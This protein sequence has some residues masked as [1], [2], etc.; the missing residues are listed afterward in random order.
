MVLGKWFTFG[1][2]NSRVKEYNLD[3]ISKIRKEF[4]KNYFEKD[5]KDY[6]NILFE[7]QKKMI[8]NEIFEVYNHYIFQMGATE[9]FSEWLKTNNTEYEKFVEWY[10]KNENIINPTE[11]NYFQFIN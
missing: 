10:T 3:S 2:L 7:Y 6:P 9:E 8:D 5:N 11:A 4:I 1:L